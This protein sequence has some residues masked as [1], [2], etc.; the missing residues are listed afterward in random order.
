MPRA[1]GDRA[2]AGIL[3][4]LTCSA[5]YEVVLPRVLLASGDG[6]LTKGHVLIMPLAIPV[7]LK[8]E[9]HELHAELAAATKV[10]GSVGEA[11]RAVANVLHP[12]FVNEEEFALPPLGVL[13]DLARGADVADATAVIAMSERLRRELP[14]MLAE[15]KAIVAALER[16]SAAA[17]AANDEPRKAFA[18][19]LLLHAQTEEEVMYPA[20]ILVGHVLLQRRSDGHKP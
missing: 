17:E 12:H 19:K 18:A 11:A 1:A 8:A 7:P 2:V 4:Q 10:P 14:S 5:E 13:S 16:L 6:E 20:A 3:L 15:H 9:H